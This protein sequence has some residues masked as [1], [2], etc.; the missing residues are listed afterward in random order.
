MLAIEHFER[1]MAVR[2]GG[3]MVKHRRFPLREECSMR[4]APGLRA[5]KLWPYPTTLPGVG[6]AMW[7]DSHPTIG[8]GCPASTILA[9]SPPRLGP[10]A[11][12]VGAV[13]GDVK[14]QDDGVMDHPADCRGGGRPV[15]FPPALVRS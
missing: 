1:L 2:M 6:A 12:S 3:Q 10:V 14:L 9:G 15:R 5:M 7:S 11:S 4:S 8:G 13:A